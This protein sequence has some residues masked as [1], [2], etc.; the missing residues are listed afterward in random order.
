MKKRYVV[1]LC[2][3]FF[4]QGLSHALETKIVVTAKSKDAKFIGTSMGGALVILRDSETGRVLQQGMIVGGTGDTKKIM[5]EPA[6]RG[7]AL[8]DSAS[9]RFATT[10]DIDE[11]RLIDVEVHAPRAQKQSL[12]VSATQVWL[13]PGKDMTGSGDGIMLE[14][15]GFSVDVLA[16][17]AH[18]K[19]SLQNG[20]AVIAIRANVVMMC[21]CPIE[22]GGIW[23]ADTYEVTAL[24]KRNVKPLEGIPLRYAGKPS[25]FEASLDITEGGAYEITVYA[26]APQ[27][28]N[29]GVDK[30]SVV[31]Q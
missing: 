27:T 6:R 4:A 23:D 28:G 12:V 3:L 16:P 24:I 11:P 31:I 8:S 13:I 17:G 5:Q 30:T 26:Y 22:P 20:K 29:T 18:E 14:V 9:A 2:V 19:I 1:C 15:P 10:V 21:G 7:I 25:T